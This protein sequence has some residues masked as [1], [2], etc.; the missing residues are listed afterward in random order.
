MKKQLFVVAILLYAHAMVSADLGEISDTSGMYSPGAA[1][2]FARTDCLTPRVVMPFPSLQEAVMSGD[3]SAVN[4]YLDSGYF[5]ET[6]SARD[7]YGK[8]VLHHAV[9]GGTK[10]HKRILASLLRHLAQMPLEKI[11]VSYQLINAQDNEG[12][13][14]LHYAVMKR[15][16]KLVMNLLNHGANATIKNYNGYDPV[17]LLMHGLK[18]CNSQSLQEWMEELIEAQSNQLEAKKCLKISLP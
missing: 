2:E 4:M 3:E 13:T 17:A 14:P 5:F 18:T 8:T 16:G 12:A 15:A 7:E 9:D 1:S 6:L 11:T 10:A